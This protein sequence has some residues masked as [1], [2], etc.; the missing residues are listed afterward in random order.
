M[1]AALLFAMLAQDRA[2]IFPDLEEARVSRRCTRSGEDITVCGDP[3]QKR[4]R[5]GEIDPRFEPRPLRPNFTLPGGGKG[6][7]EA[8]E[9]TVGGV[10]APGAMVTLDI[11][12]G[13]K[14]KK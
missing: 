10:S 14:P 11:P 7:V 6:R 8:V 9:R 12:I 3:G 2:P 1:I 4:Y 5:M 13:K